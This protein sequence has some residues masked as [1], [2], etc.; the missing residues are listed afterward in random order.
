MESIQLDRYRPGRAWTTFLKYIQTIHPPHIFEHWFKDIKVSSCTNKQ[1]VVNIANRYIKHY[2]DDHYA[3]V[4]QT[5][6]EDYG[7]IT[8]EEDTTLMA[9]P[10]ERSIYLRKEALLKIVPTL[11][12]ATYK[13]NIRLLEHYH[14]DRMKNNPR[15]AWVFNIMIYIT[16]ASG[17]DKAARVHVWTHYQIPN[18]HY[19]RLYEQIDL[20]KNRSNRDKVKMTVMKLLNQAKL[21]LSI[22][23]Q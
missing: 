20:L 23:K 21:C 16:L 2:I 22:I 11:V 6:F 17:I 13:V 10:E 15:L 1:I 18:E 8:I 19:N 9:T 3:D 4:L 7:T 5:M 12:S 14:H